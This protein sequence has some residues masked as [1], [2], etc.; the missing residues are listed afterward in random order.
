MAFPD[1]NDYG[2]ALWKGVSGFAAGYVQSSSFKKGFETVL[3]G[4]DEAGITRSLSQGNANIK[5]SFE[6]LVF[7]AG[8]VPEPSD[9]ISF[10]S[11]LTGTVNNFIVMDV[12][13]KETNTDYTR[14]TVSVEYWPGIV[15]GG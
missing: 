11:H 2:V 12:D 4:K 3:N 8:E 7:E 14:V 13:G 1:D 6:M 9:V 5:G 10:T 15:F